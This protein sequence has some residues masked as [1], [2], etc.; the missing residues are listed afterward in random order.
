MTFNRREFLAMAAVL[1]ANAAWGR[2]LGSPSSVAWQERRDFYPEGVASGDPDSNSVLLWTR[3][4]PGSSP[5]EELT[6]EVALDESF[7]KVI[8]KHTAKVSPAADWTCRV[9]VGG[10]NP[11]HVYW[12]RFTDH[13]GFGSR[14]GRTMTAPS[15]DDPRP[16]RFAFVSCQNANLGAQNAY[17]RMIFEDERAD[18]ANRLG[19][20]L[21]LG[22]FIYELVWYP[23]DKATYYDR[24]VQDIVRYPKGE[25]V[26]NF[27]IPV[28]V[29]DYRAVYR[30]YLHD[31][32][33]Q[34]ARA[35]F[36]FVPMWD[37]HEFSW[38][39]WQS[40]EVF[41]GKTRPAQ[42]RKV[43]AMQAFFEYQPARMAKP[44]G[45][46]LEQFN[47]PTVADVAVTKFDD[48]GLGQEPNNL[49]AINSL[50]GY[51]SLRW[52]KHVELIIT[53]E[54]S[55]RSPDPGT[56][57]DGDALFNK[58]FSEFIPEEVME[59]ID[60][61]REYN[62]GKPPDAIPF[63]D[64][65]VANTQKNRPPQTILG[66]EQKKWFFD[67]L[68]E[69]KA[70]WKIWGSTT[71]TLPQRADP[72]NLPPGITSSKWP[73]E[74][75]ASMGGAD[76]STA[77]H[78]L[79]QIY[80][81]VRQHEITGFAAVAGD[82]H[83]FWAGLA[84]KSLPP[85]PFDPVGVAF[86]VGSIS[87]PGGLEAYEH[88]MAKDEPLRSL[89]IGQAPADTKPQPTINM[90][91]MHGVRS[92]L[93]YCKSGDL[94]KARAL[95]NPSM[96]PQMSFVDIGGHGYAVVQAAANELE[97]EFVCIPRPVRRIDSP[98]GGPILYRARNHSRLW[99]A[100]E[101]PKLESTVVEGEA[102]FS[103]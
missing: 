72:Q 17:R 60:A 47:P 50:K 39:G 18:E 59:I 40:F 3:H 1:G 64:K 76:M 73:G 48:N 86:V 30:S 12:Y 44:S 4:L 27:H 29:D 89:F 79:G 81:F 31:P 74:A 75:Y 36:P 24:Q 54:R 53:D 71:A 43:A 55:Y 80:D 21:H 19:F 83:S 32:D 101:P 34:D 16:V 35:R 23:E 70:T 51:R 97:T 95:S 7:R 9:L 33:L 8:A 63:G 99:R 46:S 58:D 98:D 26:S 28:D 103:V 87:S 88:K 49:A 91:L 96:A 61:G 68:R 56:D 77:S 57:L 38:Q 42:T 15:D 6:V 92:C 65:K 10:L 78:E 13:N 62:G 82:R 90:L 93:E 84:S 102:R 25:K 20:V 5:V 37:N 100:G 11:G 85:K 94:A 67:Q 69:S 2:G 41:D 45:P 66:A 14:I 52:G 22:D